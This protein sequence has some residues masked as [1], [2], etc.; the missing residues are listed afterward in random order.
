MA[1]TGNKGIDVRQ[2][3][4]RLIFRASLK[5]SSGVRLAT[6]TTT[7]AILELQDDG[8][9]KTYD[10]SSN[11]F[12]TSSMTTSGSTASMT[13]RSR[14]GDSD[15]AVTLGVWTYVLSTLTGFTEGA[16]YLVTVSNSG[17]MP[18]QQEREFQYGSHEGDMVITANGTGVGY[19]QS[20]VKA[21]NGSTASAIRIALSAGVILPGTVSNAVL[22]PTT[23]A[24]AA[25]DITEAT[26]DHYIGRAIIFTSGALL[27]Q[28]CRILDY[29]LVSGEGNFTVS[30]LTEAPAND[31][32]FIIV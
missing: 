29:A 5:D 28:G 20:D 25:D 9:F 27:G 18:L 26:A 19:V 2:T 3:G 21:L 17:A 24:F 23:S 30:T 22:T 11:T 6:G 15:A 16:I 13:H 12:K 14:I 8:T 32:T 31:V 4:N 10:F 1:A 7:I